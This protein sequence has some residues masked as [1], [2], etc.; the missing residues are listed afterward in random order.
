MNTMFSHSA[1]PAAGL[2]TLLPDTASALMV[3]ASLLLADLER[4]RAIDAKALRAAMTAGSNG[5]DA[6]GAWDW[7]TAYDACEAAQVLFLRKFGSAMRARAASP[8]AL[9]AMLAKIAAL[10]PS[11]TRRSEESQ[12]LQQFSTPIALGFAVSAAAAITPADL[13]LEPSAGTGLL[14]IFAELAGASLVLNELAGTRADL[15]GHLF[16]GVSVTRHDAAHIHDHLDAALRPSQDA[17]AA[18]V[19]RARRPR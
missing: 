11:H 12:A 3:A 19:P 7:K 5:C 9:L 8:A 1:A 6:E 18:I 15:L 4:G 2:S 10:L 17:T 16:P 14:A 13:V